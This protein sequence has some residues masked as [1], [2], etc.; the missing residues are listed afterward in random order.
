MNKELDLQR[1]GSVG[2]GVEPAFYGKLL[3]ARDVL[4]ALRHVDDDDEKV[5]ERLAE[6]IKNLEKAEKTT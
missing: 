5:R 1:Y 3:Q 4:V 6:L 2:Y